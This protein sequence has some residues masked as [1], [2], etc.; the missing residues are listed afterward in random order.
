MTPFYQS[1]KKKGRRSAIIVSDSTDPYS[2]YPTLDLNTIPFH[3]AAGGW[4]AQSAV[5]EPS[6]P[7][8]TT[9][10]SVGTW[11]AFESACLTPG[12][13]ITV[14]ASISGVGNPV[15]GSM[16]DIDIIVNPGVVINNPI[17]GRFGQ[18]DTITRVRM[19]GPTL[20]QYS[21]GQVHNA[22][23]F[24]LGTDIIFT[25]IG[26]TGGGANKEV[27]LESAGGLA[28]NR[29]AVT[30]CRGMTGNSFFL[31]NV[32]NLVAAGNSIYSGA[33]LTTVSP[34]DEAWNFRCTE[35]RGPVIL[36]DN[37]MRNPRFHNVRYHPNN[38]ALNQGYVW[39][40]SNLIVDLEEARIFWTGRA[41]AGDSG[42]VLGSWFLNNT[43]YAEDNDVIFTP[44]I[45]IEHCPYG[46]IT[47]NVFYGDFDA[48]DIYT[49]TV[50][51]VVVS[52]NTFNGSAA[53][54]AWTRAGDPTGLDWT[55]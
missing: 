45:E 22:R 33:D 6:T 1:S 34:N 18:G 37:D 55:P 26:M 16:T 47:G 29:W 14:T 24:G 7:V 52:S 11:A 39:V 42:N 35:G 4:G 8:T 25:G 3:T 53:E 17:F 32:H 9:Q 36:Y 48:G 23:V 5:E 20:G 38:A 46:R 40:A 12:T 51:D 10:T 50:A 30:Y 41:S 27:A 54:P 49:S 2:L 13:E 31:G 28:H 15:S 21:G 44:D 43:I 19:R